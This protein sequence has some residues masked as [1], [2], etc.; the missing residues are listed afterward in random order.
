MNNDFS[1]E[2]EILGKEVEDEVSG[3]KGIASGISIF[4]HGCARVGV[5]PKIKKDGTL[6]DPKWVDYPQLIIKESKKT[7]VKK[8]ERSK[9]GGPIPSIPTRNT[10][11]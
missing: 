1:K 2:L 7:K 9:T 5:Q 10:S 11:K 8:E 6:D 4:L 3:F